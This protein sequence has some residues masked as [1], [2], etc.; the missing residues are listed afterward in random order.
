M[1]KEQLQKDTNNALKSGDQIKRL[2]LGM[3]LNSIKS[4]EVIKR[5]QLAK[6]I[7]DRDKLE[8]QSQLNDDEVIETIASEIKKRKE[9]I[10]QFSTGGRPELAQK[11]K[12][13]MAILVSYMP[14][15]I[16]ENEVR[17]EIQ[18]TIADLGAK[19]IKEMGKVIAAIMAKLKG[20][21]E[22]SLVSRI[23]K[24]ELLGT[25]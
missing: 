6:T 21:A 11:E 23:V 13:E 5:T 12:T 2:V 14:A 25:K 10:E 19:D 15:Q 3:L 18:K 9:A 16:P 7:N 8:N 17:A 4:R 20:Q 22:G 1:L 24:E